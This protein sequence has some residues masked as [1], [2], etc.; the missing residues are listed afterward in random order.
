LS[1]VI[2]KVK[3]DLIYAAAMIALAIGRRLPRSVGLGIFGAIGSIVYLFPNREKQRTLE[4]LKLIYG[5]KWDESK[6]KKTAGQVYHELGKNLFDAFYLSK[7]KS[8]EIKK[9]VK[10][11]SLEEFSEAY[12]MGKGVIVITAH[13]GCFEMLLHYFAIQGF[14]C[15]AIGRRLYDGRLEKI[16]RG[17]RSGENIEYMN[18]SESTMKIMRNLREGKVFGVLIDQDTNVEGVFADFLGLPAYTPS[19]PV[20]MAMKFGI[21]VFVSTT[22]RC[23]DNTHYVFLK[24]LSLTDTGNFDADLVENVRVANSYICETIR[25]YPSQWVWMHRRWKRKP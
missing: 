7:V 4:H 13:V 25:S 24:R 16:I 5:D 17:Q 21:P 11:E 22:V 9:I 18:R 3:N 20:K 12:R 23:R 2:K 6:I 14:R 8:E 1:P 15:F 10:K 19:G